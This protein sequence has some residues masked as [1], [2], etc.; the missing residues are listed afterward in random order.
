MPAFA[1]WSNGSRQ[2]RFV[3]AVVP[4]K[5][6]WPAPSSTPR[7]LPKA[8]GFDDG[9][10]VRGRPAS[11]CTARVPRFPPMASLSPLGQSARW[12]ISGSPIVSTSVEGSRLAERHLATTIHKPIV[13]V[14]RPSDGGRRPLMC[15]S[16]TSRSY[17]ARLVFV[18][19]GPRWQS[20]LASVAMAL[21][22]AL[23]LR[24]LGKV[25]LIVR[26]GANPPA[27]GSKR[28]SPF[29]LGECGPLFRTPAATRS[30]YFGWT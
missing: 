30:C 24:Y 15:H 29:W 26:H 28:K 27:M 14:F 25:G 3:V 1:E 2:A 23:C 8:G 4:L 5:A 17:S 6:L 7:D 9:P 21:P 12:A 19:S 16:S 18:P 13:K 10:F 11:E 20:P 22:D